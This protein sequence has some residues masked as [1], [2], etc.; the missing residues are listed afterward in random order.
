MYK[1]ILAAAA[2]IFASMILVRALENTGQLSGQ[3]GTGTYYVTYG[4]IVNVVV[5]GILT[6]VTRG[7]NWLHVFSWSGLAASIAVIFSDFIDQG[8]FLNQIP[9]TPEP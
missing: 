8:G 5:W 7:K 9:E 6:A 4:A 3:L 1:T 2:G